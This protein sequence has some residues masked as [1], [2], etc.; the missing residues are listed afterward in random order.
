MKH[1]QRRGKKDNGE[2]G[3]IDNLNIKLNGNQLLNVTDDAL[4]A[5]KYSSFNFIDGANENT[6]YEYNGNGALVKDLNRG[7]QNIEYDL[8]G[9][10]I[11]IDFSNKKYIQY[12]YTP[13]GRKISKAHVW[14]SPILGTISLNED[15]ESEEEISITSRMHCISYEYGENTVYRNS[16][17]YY[18]IFPGGF[19]TMEEGKPVFHYYTQDHLGNNRNVVNEDGTIEQA[20]HYYPFGGTFN[21]IGIDSE[22]QQYKYNGKELD[23]M[24]GLDTYDYG[25]R[26]YFSVLPIWDRIDPKC[27]EDYHISPY[28]YCKNNPIRMIDKSGEKPGDFFLSADAA[29]FDFGTFYNDNSIRENREYGAYIYKVTNKEGITGYSYSFAS[30]GNK[31]S[32]TIDSAPMGHIPVAVIH[33]HGKST[34]KDSRKFYDNEFSGIRNDESNSLKNNEERLNTRDKDIGFSNNRKINSYLVTP[35]GTLQKYN[36]NTGRI[37]ILS[38]DMPSDKNDPN[39]VNSNQSDFEQN[40]LSNKEIID[41]N[42]KIMYEIY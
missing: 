23:R 25:A 38:H 12:S 27:E 13:D 26:Q 20:T 6:E 4:P 10:P 35:S 31:K 3:K 41:I 36:Y 39:R 8:S 15:I 2:Y 16:N 21:D 14:A 5:N 18:I 7:I 42:K 24:Y 22:F 30:I 34:F 37:K 1:F 33:T 9:N 28:A 32:V 11:N 17:I 29:A 19:C 40:P